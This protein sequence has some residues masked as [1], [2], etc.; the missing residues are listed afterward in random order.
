MAKSNDSDRSSIKDPEQ[1]EALRDE[2]MSKEKAA[3][4]ANTS[5]KKAGKKGGK[6]PEHE[7]W[8]REQLY[9]KAQQIGI[10]GRSD[11]DK[12]DLIKALRSH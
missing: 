1:Y 2:G 11:M 9:E 5:R 8:T 6:H 10:E 7:E 12:N 3:R 4:I